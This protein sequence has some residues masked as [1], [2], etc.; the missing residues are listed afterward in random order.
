VE[1]RRERSGGSVAEATFSAR[2]I[3]VDCQRLSIH[4]IWIFKGRKL[5]LRRELRRN[6]AGIKTFLKRIVFW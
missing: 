4:R 6:E 2:D 3:S 1:Y 5:V